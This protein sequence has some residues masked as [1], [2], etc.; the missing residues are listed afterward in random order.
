MN[1]YE[2]SVLRAV[3]IGIIALI[4]GIGIVIARFVELFS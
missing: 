2:R 1:E 3:V 4:I